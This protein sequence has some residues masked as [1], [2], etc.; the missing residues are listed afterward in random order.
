M[1]QLIINSEFKYDVVATQIWC[2]LV[3]STSKPKPLF[4]TVV[5][6]AESLVEPEVEANAKAPA[7]A[8]AKAP[9]TKLSTSAAK[10]RIDPKPKVADNYKQKTGRRRQNI[11]V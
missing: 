10:P 4:T 7:K 8:K 11:A 6:T 1:K 9:S 2:K 5:V 3:P